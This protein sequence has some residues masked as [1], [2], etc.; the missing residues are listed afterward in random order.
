MNQHTY[1]AI[2]FKFRRNRDDSLET[3]KIFLVTRSLKK[4]GEIYPIN[5]LN[6]PLVFNEANTA[7]FTIYKENDSIVMPLFDKIKNLSVILIEGV[8]YFQIS[9]PTKETDCVQKDITATALQE[10]ELSQTNI[11][12]EVNTDDDLEVQKYMPTTFYNPSIPAQSLLN[13]VIADAA[14]HYKIGHVDDSLWDIQQE[15][16]ASDEDVW[17]FF[18][19]I[20]DEIGCIFICDPFSRTINV[21]DMQYHCTNVE[22]HDK[23]DDDGNFIN[24]HNKRHIIDGV[25]TICGAKAEEGYGLNSSTFVDTTN[26]ASAIQDSIETDKIKN[27][28]KITGGDDIVNNMIRQRIIGN[29]NRI[30]CMSQ[31]QIEEMSEPLQKKWKEYQALL[32]EYQDD[33]AMLWNRWN[34]YTDEIMYWQSGRSPIIEGIPGT[35]DAAGYCKKIYNDLIS[36][37]T[38]GCVRSK[39]TTLQKLSKDILDYATLLCPTGYAVKWQQDANANDKVRIIEQEN[40]APITKWGG[41]LYV[42]LKNYPDPEDES[43]DKYF[44]KPETEWILSVR[45][46]DDSF[47]YMTVDGQKVF[48]NEYYEYLK[49]MMDIQLANL[50]ITFDPKYYDDPKEEAKHL[51]DADYYKNYYAGYCPHCHS[52][53]VVQGKCTECNSTDVQ[54]GYSINRL[55]GIRDGYRQVTVLLGELD[56]TVNDSNLFYQLV[57]DN[58][59]DKVSPKMMFETLTAKYS[60]MADY[61][62]ELIKNY[63]DKVDALKVEQNHAQLG[64][65]TINGICN[66]KNYLG[67]DLYYEFLS[68]KREQVYSNDNFTSETID[69]AT[70]MQNVE[71]LIRDAKE[72]AAKA[73]QFEHTITMSLS[74]LMSLIQYADVYDAFALGNYFRIRI[75]GKDIKL[76]IISIS[77]DFENIESCEITFADASIVTNEASKIGSTIKQAASLATSYETAKKQIDKNTSISTAF[78]KML[79]EG[80]SMTQTHIMSTNNAEVLFD[81]CGLLGRQ[82]NTDTNNY[83]PSQTRLNG[84]GLLFTNDNWKTPNIAIGEIVWNGKQITGII[85]KNLIGEMIIGNNLEIS[86][87]SGSYTITNDGFKM[88]QGTKYIEMNPSKPYF[89]LNNGSETLFDFNGD[90]NGNLTFGSSVKLNWANI[91]DTPTFIDEDAVTEITRNTITTETLTANNL[92]AGSLVTKSNEYKTTIKSGITNIECLLPNYVPHSIN[93]YDDIQEIVDDESFGLEIQAQKEHFVSD[94]TDIRYRSK[95]TPS[96]ILLYKSTSYMTGRHWTA[97]QTTYINYDGTYVK[98]YEDNPSTTG[99]LQYIG[100]TNLLADGTYVKSDIVA[101]RGNIVANGTIQGSSPSYSCTIAS[102]L[103]LDNTYTNK[104][105]KVLDAVVVSLK[106]NGTIDANTWVTVATLPKQCTPMF[107]I[108]LLSIITDAPASNRCDMRI[109]GFNT[110]DEGIVSKQAGEIQVFQHG[111]TKP[112]KLHINLT[113]PIN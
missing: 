39:N 17:S 3:P 1:D 97:Y 11:T 78:N 74:N 96:T 70:L 27:C 104:I 63:T 95:F 87:Q 37:I 90:G 12:I 55:S 51:D 30:W 57:V 31:D 89:K 45:C 47:K 60:V 62:D 36:Q 59:P 64:I 25:C 67:D 99:S 28:F 22:Y 44:Y 91:E 34:K 82:F 79:D 50:D 42:Y 21:F 94:N 88:T 85:A 5:N 111:D 68:F 10:S 43:K 102:G 2:K 14:P 4:I 18:T 49:R 53:T 41:Y 84:R 56:S 98:S 9:L 112:T 61:I 40:N 32:A 113:Y 86:N 77:I 54:E 69:E 20:A 46:G 81:N 76:R 103:T 92:T 7:T 19:K 73:C 107:N 71:E 13:R 48:S 23:K 33:F 24:E 106:L 6:L 105:K 101:T 75:D 109:I 38:Y 26:L 83:E 100:D 108:P 15:F 66:F 58:E 8:G 80:L 35:E 72:E 52:H 110:N 65:T 16:S 93:N 29:T